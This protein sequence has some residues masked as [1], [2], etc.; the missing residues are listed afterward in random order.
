MM[1]YDDKDCLDQ[2]RREECFRMIRWII[3]DTTTAVAILDVFE[4]DA[5]MERMTEAFH[6]AMEHSF[7]CF[8]PFL[9]MKMSESHEGS[10]ALAS[11]FMNKCGPYLKR[12]SL[13]KGFCYEI[14]D[15]MEEKRKG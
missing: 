12:P 2:F 13:F 15:Q 4:N 5:N 10:Q 8:L 11:A 1:L 3:D 14:I 9:I 7:Y 6:A